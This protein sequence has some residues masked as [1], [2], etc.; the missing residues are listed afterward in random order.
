[1]DFMV[2]PQNPNAAIENS[3]R[4]DMAKNRVRHAVGIAVPLMTDAFTHGGTNPRM[5]LQSLIVVQVK[6]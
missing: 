2:P 5:A 3:H 4:G 1:M 6:D